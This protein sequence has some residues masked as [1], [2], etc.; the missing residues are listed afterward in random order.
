MRRRV[1]L[2]HLGTATAPRSAGSGF[3]G[4]ALHLSRS[5]RARCLVT[6]LAP[7]HA[8]WL[9]RWTYAFVRGK[10]ACEWQTG[11]AGIHRSPPPPPRLQ[12][13]DECPAFICLVLDAH[14]KTR[15]MQM[16][17]LVQVPRVVLSVI[18][19]IVRPHVQPHTAHN[20]K[21]KKERW[22]RKVRSFK[23][24]IPSG[25]KRRGVEHFIVSGSDQPSAVSS[26]T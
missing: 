21:K 12:R 4:V 1:R 9:P 7:C 10:H 2:K 15:C 16:R 13:C 11:Q 24:Q 26:M 25:L 18:M 8:P 22:V 23:T 14:N 19:C 5:R 20:A 6:L 17:C 3:A